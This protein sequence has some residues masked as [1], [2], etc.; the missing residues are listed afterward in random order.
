MVQI[1]YLCGC[2]TILMTCAPRDAVTAARRGRCSLG[3]GIVE[4]R[5]RLNWKG[6]TSWHT[7]VK[8]SRV[9]P[10]C[11]RAKDH[12][13]ALEEALDSLVLMDIASSM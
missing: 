6:V 13:S 12:D 5:C 9:A 8:C 11:L 3:I 2:V 1:S 7:S 10:E 4:L